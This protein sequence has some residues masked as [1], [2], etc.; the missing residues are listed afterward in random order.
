MAVIAGVSP[1]S[2]PP[3]LDRA[4]GGEQRGGAFVAPHDDLQ[5]VLG[6]GQRQLAHAEIVDDEQR[7]GGQRR[8][9]LFAR[10]VEGRVGEGFEQRVGSRYST[11]CP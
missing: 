7:H 2:F 11:R 5:E 1:S 9:Q 8:H 10:A 4:I 6:G 3:V